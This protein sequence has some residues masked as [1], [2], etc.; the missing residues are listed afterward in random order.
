MSVSSFQLEG[1]RKGADI[2]NSCI[3]NWCVSGL[4]LILPLLTMFLSTALMDEL[5]LR[6]EHHCHS[7][8]RHRTHCNLPSAF[9]KQQ[10]LGAMIDI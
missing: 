8:A 10:R 4:L 3:L 2:L 7:I 1:G 5:G 6:L 9:Y